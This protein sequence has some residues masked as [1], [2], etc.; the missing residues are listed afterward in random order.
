MDLFDLRIVVEQVD[1]SEVTDMLE[2]PARSLVLQH[3]SDAAKVVR[4]VAA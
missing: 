2:R 4:R 3:V 1:L